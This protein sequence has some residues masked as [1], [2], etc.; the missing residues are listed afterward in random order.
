MDAHHDERR[1]P[2][3]AYIPTALVLHAQGGLT[4]AEWASF[5]DFRDRIINAL[6]KAAL[7]RPSNEIG[8]PS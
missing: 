6:T 2:D 8:F 4:A 3:S 1:N 7:S 5:V